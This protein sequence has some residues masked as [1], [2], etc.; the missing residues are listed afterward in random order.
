VALLLLGIVGCTRNVAVDRG[1]G[2]QAYY[3]TGSPVEDVSGHIERTLASVVRIHVEG[4]YDRYVFP[5]EGAPVASD[6]QGVLASL[7]AHAM[8]TIPSSIAR[9]ATAVII[10][11]T[12]G[13]ITLLTTHHAIHFPEA[14][15][16]Y[17]GPQ[18]GTRPAGVERRIESIS[19]RIGQTSAIVGPSQ[20]VEPF[21]ILASAEADDLALIGVRRGVDH[22]AGYQPV[23]QAAPEVPVLDL[24]VGDPRRLSW[25]SFVYVLGHPGGF[26]MV[27]RGIVSE[28]NRTAEGAFLM[29]GLWNE[30]MSGAPIVA[31]R[32]DNGAFEWVG[33]ARAAAART[34][35]RIE[36]EEGAV[37]SQ[38]LRRPY[39]GP[40][41]LRAIE[42]IRPGISFSIPLT[43]A[44]R[45]INARRPELA[46][47]GF[48][49]PAP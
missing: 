41:Y 34:T 12:E 14:I 19:I 7:L 33:I 40:L 6:V 46:D 24:T 17:R 23:P 29:D 11:G 35:Y 3:Q 39:E 47:S 44:R 1:R 43:A 20:A 8:D 36:A 49:L 48:P 16:E 32:G 28:P 31:V 42:E 9:A 18:E 37:R 27:T 10:A 45:F 21:E 25:G 22:A 26:R 4:T 30:G 13:A 38:D 5:E 2:P 15:V